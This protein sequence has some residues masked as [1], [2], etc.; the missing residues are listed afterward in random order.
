MEYQY[1]HRRRV[2]F[3]ETDQAGLVHFS[4]FFRYMESAEHA[5]VRSLG[6]SI[7]MNNTS[8]P[9]GWPRVNVACEF[10]KPVH[11]EDIVDI[12][13]LISKLSKRSISYV[14]RVWRNEDESDVEVA[15][16]RMT[17]VCVSR[18]E[19]GKITPTPIPQEFR[20][21][22]CEA[23]KEMVELASKH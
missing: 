10:F 4:N 23:P 3:N 7:A 2:E 21:K 11:F 15:R 12:Q 18:D 5:F 14:F 22:L 1:R 9:V 6:F 16:G 8:P 13:L 19:A 20:D 17:A